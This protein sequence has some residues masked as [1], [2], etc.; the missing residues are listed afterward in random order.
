MNEPSIPFPTHELEQLLEKFREAQARADERAKVTHERF[1]VFTTI[2]K[3]DDEVRLHTRFLHCLLD[4]NG[5]HDCDSKFLDL[6]FITLKESPNVKDGSDKLVPLEI[7]QTDASWS[8]RKEVSCPD[9]QID[10]LFERPGFKIAIEN[11]INA[12]EQRGQLAR[13]SKFLHQRAD[14]TTWLIYLTKE[15]KKSETPEGAPYIRISY[16]DHILPWLEKCLRETH[17]IIPINQVLQQYRAVVRKLTGKNL[18]T[19]AMKEISE[20]ITSH[21]DI[22]RFRKHLDEGINKACIGFFKSLANEIKSVLELHGFQVRQPEHLEFG[23][24]PRGA[25][26]IKTPNNIVPFDIYVEYAP[27]VDEQV[28]AVGISG[29]FQ[30]Q[31][32]S[33]ERNDLCQRMYEK[34][35]AKGY[36]GEGVNKNWPTGWHDLIDGLDDDGIANQVKIGPTKTAS[37]VC[38][39]IRSYIKQLEEIYTE[40]IQQTSI[41]T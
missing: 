24:H 32:L 40:V 4:P 18:E 37:E 15:G 8:I 3:A 23:V 10:I 20:F 27:G 19:K 30:N 13:Y 39:K 26:V 11:K 16:A 17:D 38:D 34:L 5:C 28:L 12:Y 31:P 33:L 9:G 7:T 29:D 41:Q 22:I 2:L 35:K 25:L 14:D 1:N 21:P 36:A 6:F